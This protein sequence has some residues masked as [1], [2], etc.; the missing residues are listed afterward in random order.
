L[1]RPAL[2]SYA[3]GLLLGFGLSACANDPGETCSAG[4]LG[5]ECLA[6]AC[7]GGLVCEADVCS[8]PDVADTNDEISTDDADES[9]TDESP[10]DESP[11]DESP[12]DE[13]PTDEST[14]ESTD[15]DPTT[16]TSGDPCAGTEVLLYSQNAG[17][18]GQGVPSNLVFEFGAGAEAADDFTIP[19]EDSCWCITEVRTRGMWADG[20]GPMATPAV[21]ASIQTDDL[22]VP[23]GIEIWSHFNPPDSATQADFVVSTPPDTIVESGEYWFVF[24]PVLGL[25][26]AFEAYWQWELET[27]MSGSEAH[28]RDQVDLFY[29]DCLD[30]AP[31]DTCTTIPPG[32][33]PSLRFDIY[34]VLGGSDCN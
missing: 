21:Y 13:S 6:G 4:S 27:A 32:Y 25:A 26:E 24:A 23:S 5:C 29:Q 19:A 10:T 15:D 9:P 1:A 8:L 7:V 30:W 31:L 11:T 33:Q 17:A 3:V 12:T 18:L 2:T 34:G 28:V 14:S 20:S 22:G 16:D